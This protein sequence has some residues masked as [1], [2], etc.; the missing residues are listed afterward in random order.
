VDKTTP[1]YER[2][3]TDADVIGTLRGG[4][5][6]ARAPQ[7]FTTQGC[8]GGWYPV[9][10]R[11]F[12]CVGQTATLN[13]SHPTLAVMKNQPNRQAPLPY[14]YFAATRPTDL[15][16][17][18]RGKGAAVRTVGK[19]RRGSRLAVVGSWTA[20]IPEGKTA[21]LALLPDGRFVQADHLKEDSAS[22]FAGTELKEALA[23]PIAYVVRNG[24]RYWRLDGKDPHKLKPIANRTM[25]A[26][27]GRFRTVGDLRFWATPD[28]TYVRHRDV[29][30]VRRRDAFP[31]FAT[32]DQKWI[33][34]SVI[35]GA[36]VLYEGRKPV[37]ATLCSV[38]HD[39]IG[40]PERSNATAM[41][42]FT[43]TS[44][45]LTT[46]ESGSK[47][48]DDSLD[49][50][51]VPWALGLSSGQLVHAATWHSRFGIEHGPGNI[52]LSPRDAAHVFAWVTPELAEGWHSLTK[53][54]E[55][56]PKVIVLVRK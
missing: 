32:G 50:L 5:T 30:V 44:K 26:L 16:V 34:V 56:D 36:M 17:W 31:E 7:P 39:R 6:V 54:G 23:L 12:V 21:P 46:S 2:P 13:L 10:P 48:F 43:I 20:T 33:D 4:A 42:V 55:S 11:G 15:Y 53:L 51:D 1:V 49:A 9:R 24:I 45:H 22:N 19:L 8:P 38:G 35:T 3:S 47:P 14:P 52:Q 27:T 29:T 37:F 25:V 41:G 40:N 18:D 28:E